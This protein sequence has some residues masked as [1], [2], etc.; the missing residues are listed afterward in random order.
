MTELQPNQIL[1]QMLFGAA[2]TK[3]LG[4]AAELGIADLLRGGPRTVAELA[5]GADV[6]E[7]ELYR[8]LR[9]LSGVGLFAELPGQ[10]FQLTP[11][12]ELLRQDAPHSLRNMVRM[13]AF[14]EHWNA[15]DSLLTVVRHGGIATDIAEGMDVWDYFR[16]HP[17]RAEIF[18]DAMTNMSRQSNET[19][20]SSFEFGNYGCVCDVGGGHGSQLIA[21]LKQH[22]QIN[23]MVFDQD[24]VITGAT[25]AFAS[26]G[27]DGRARAVGGN[28][29]ESVAP[30]A[31]VYIAKNIIHDWDDEKAIRILKN[32]RAAIPAD[33]RVLLL[34]LMVGPP[35]VPAPGKFI[36]ITMMALTGGKERTAEEFAAL[37]EASGFKLGRV[38]P[39][40]SPV[41]LVEGIP[42]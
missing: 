12:S 18:D 11:V 39:T 4:I 14:G 16:T 15:W 13:T 6:R 27:L 29:F 9:M 21:I 3:C 38:I 33:G 37:Y 42:A 30:G 32:I 8:I 19:I 25:T 40:R 2:V 26:A 7:A 36:D 28:F 35:N 24:Y 1:L 5:A 41:F 31:D 34:E 17:D 22:P 10:Q 23:G 20:A